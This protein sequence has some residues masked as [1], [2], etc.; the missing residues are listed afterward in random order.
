MRY[1]NVGSGERRK[2]AKSVT[3]ERNCTPMSTIEM[4]ALG[5]QLKSGT[6]AVEDLRMADRLIMVLVRLLPRDSTIVLPD[7]LHDP[8]L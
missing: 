4:C 7:G 8:A 6:V 1:A 2:R 5:V 3:V